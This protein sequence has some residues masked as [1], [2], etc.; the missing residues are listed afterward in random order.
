MRDTPR[1][2]MKILGGVCL[3]ALVLPAVERPVRPF[4]MLR[5]QF[6]AEGLPSV[7]RQALWLTWMDTLGQRAGQPMRS[8]LCLHE[9]Q[10][11]VSFFRCLNYIASPPLPVQALLSALQAS[12]PLSHIK[13]PTVTNCY[14]SDTALIEGSQWAFW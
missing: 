11:G 3:G 2:W 12:T 14:S 5:M 1:L 13:F 7:D 8:F 9:V 4:E 6:T 10:V